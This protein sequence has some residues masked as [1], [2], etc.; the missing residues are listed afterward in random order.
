MTFQNLINRQTDRATKLSHYLPQPG[1]VDCSRNPGTAHKLLNYYKPPHCKKYTLEIF[2]Q[3]CLKILISARLEPVLS[4]TEKS[5]LSSNYRKFSA[6]IKIIKLI[7]VLKAMAYVA[8]KT[9]SNV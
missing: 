2:F 1:H 6:N 7:S 4:Y 9:G 5:C 3:F 8:K